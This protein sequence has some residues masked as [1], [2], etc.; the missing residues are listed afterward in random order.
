MKQR[1]RRPR[2]AQGMF[3]PRVKKEKEQKYY[4]PK[5]TFELLELAG[6][7]YQMTRNSPMEVMSALA[8]RVSLLLGYPYLSKLTNNFPANDLFALRH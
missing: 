4:E 3:K 7:N 2:L 1:N 8:V 5:S 6:G